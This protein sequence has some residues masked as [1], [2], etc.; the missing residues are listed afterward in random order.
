MWTAQQQ[1]KRDE[2]C[3][4]AISRTHS[5]IHF[6]FSPGMR[7]QSSAASIHLLFFLLKKCVR[8]HF[9]FS[10]FIFCKF[11]FW[12]FCFVSP[13]YLTRTHSVMV[14]NISPS[15]P[16]KHN[17][18]VGRVVVGGLSSWISAW[19]RLNGVIRLSEFRTSTLWDERKVYMAI[20]ASIFNWGLFLD[21]SLSSFDDKRLCAL[22][23]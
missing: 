9:R 10:F 22:L 16:L 18:S 6:Y 17:V 2:R 12:F 11:F 1:S 15:A 20:W 19:L 5:Q 4:C 23:Y 21:Q 13:Y 7:I 3:H 8:L 14:C